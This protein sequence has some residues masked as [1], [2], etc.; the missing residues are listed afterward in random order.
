M[1]KNR[2]L[3]KKKTDLLNALGKCLSTRGFPARPS[4]Y[5]FRKKTAFGNVAVHLNVA[6]YE[7]EFHAAVHVSVRFDAVE[8]LINACNELLTPAEKK[9]TATFGCELG[10]LRDGRRRE[11]RVVVGRSDPEKIAKEMAELVFEIGVPYFE[12]Y[13]SLEEVYAVFSSD[14]VDAGIHVAPPLW[15]GER[16]VALGFVIGGA[17]EARRMIEAKRKYFGGQNPRHARL[18]EKFVTC[19]EKQVGM[20]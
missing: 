1:T 15:R 14:D 5:S 18:F 6:Q 13:S 10:N 19:F 4:G 7:T 3:W 20:E 12:R 9:K 16:A 11:W 2:E 8:D 17:A